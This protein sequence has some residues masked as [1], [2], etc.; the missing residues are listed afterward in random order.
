MQFIIVHLNFGLGIFETGLYYNSD[1]SG[2]HSDAQAD[3][4]PMAILLLLPPRCWD[5]RYELPHLD[6]ASAGIIGT[7]YHIWIQFIYKA[8]VRLG[9][10]LTLQT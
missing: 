10:M 3:F 2:T 4:Q 5:Y 6:P 9:K 7:S 8:E 1:H